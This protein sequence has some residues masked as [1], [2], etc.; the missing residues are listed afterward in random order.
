MNSYG[1]G[2]F[3]KGGLLSVSVG[4]HLCPALDPTIL[5]PDFY[6]PF[7]VLTK[8]FRPC[9]WGGWAR[10]RVGLWAGGGLSGQERNSF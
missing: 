8:L 4:F 6:G 1:D 2:P 9:V 5:D 10:G 3:R 7:C